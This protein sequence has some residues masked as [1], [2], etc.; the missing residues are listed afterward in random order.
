MHYGS[1]FRLQQFLSL[2]K[3]V[4]LIW[5]SVKGRGCSAA[6]RGAASSRLRFDG[7]ALIDCRH[8]ITRRQVDATTAFREAGRSFCAR[9]DAPGATALDV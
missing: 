1:I 9:R 7:S 2:A 4:L 5:G 6:G 8:R 3:S